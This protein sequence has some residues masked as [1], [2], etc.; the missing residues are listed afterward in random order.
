MTPM[1]TVSPS[2]PSTFPQADVA[3]VGL[4][5]FFLVGDSHQ[6][7]ICFNER[8]GRK[9]SGLFDW[10]S[11]SN[12]R[13]PY[14]LLE[15]QTCVKTFPG[16]SF[17]SECRPK[18]DELERDLIQNRVQNGFRIYC[19][20]FLFI[21]FHRHF[22]NKSFLIGII[23]I[24]SLQLLQYIHLLKRNLPSMGGLTYTNISYLR[25]R[26]KSSSF[27]KKKCLAEVFGTCG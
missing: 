24:I 18:N 11:C 14:L 22:A 3:C 1:Y 19:S 12:A 27:L 4:C 9:H 25:K 7:N 15:S 20:L 5:G 26:Q 10:L 16:R 2:S 21:N 23:I 8:L 17:L 13:E 6:K